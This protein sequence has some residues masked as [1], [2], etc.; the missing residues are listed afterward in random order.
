[1]T[2][3]KSINVISV[4]HTVGLASSERAALI[5]RMNSDWQCISRAAK[6][7]FC[8][9][10]EGCRERFVSFVGEQKS[11][12]QRRHALGITSARM[13]AHPALS[14]MRSDLTEIQAK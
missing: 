14:L 6:D 2:Q 3:E 1:M 13:S 10:P 12:D 8:M 9:I 5:H 7:R 11:S 4:A